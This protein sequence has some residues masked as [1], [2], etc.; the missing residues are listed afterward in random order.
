MASF[1]EVE[2]D[3][4]KGLVSKGNEFFDR[5]DNGDASALDQAVAL[6]LDAA[7]MVA[8]VPEFDRSR[9]YYRL[10]NALFRRFWNSQDNLS[11]LEEAIK[12]CRA[13]LA[14]LPSRH[15]EIS[16]LQ[17]FLGDALSM[18]FQRTG[19]RNDLDQAVD[20]LE[21]ALNNL[22]LLP[23]SHLN[24]WKGPTHHAIVLVLRFEQGGDPADLHNAII[25]CRD[26]LKLIPEDHP[27][28][29]S[30]LNNLG[31]ALVRRFYQTGERSDLDQGITYTMDAL[32]TRSIG[33]SER[34]VSLNSLGTALRNRY[35]HLGDPV[36]LDNAILTQREAVELT[37][38]EHYR[39][40]LNLSEC[41][42][43]RNKKDQTCDDLEEAITI[44]R[45]ILKGL[46]QWHHDRPLAYHSLSLSLLK[47]FNLTGDEGDLLEAAEHC[48]CALGLRPLGHPRRL[49]SLKNLS[50]IAT[51]RFLRI[52]PTL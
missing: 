2:H 45:K 39:Y 38:F 37:V 43:V 3:K 50:D 29:I 46:P 9:N 14:C 34:G 28:R 26:S 49:E 24:Q 25:D 47:R 42:Y 20:R 23:S 21:D 41:L 44:A 12:Y 18:R 13:A 40:L 52:Y 36:D 33:P 22:S 7:T 8:E 19:D 1:I 51:A 10:G 17:I 30:C 35:E 6:F 27:D 31:K 48:H 15:P 5:Y 16:T 32:K 11:D 4:W